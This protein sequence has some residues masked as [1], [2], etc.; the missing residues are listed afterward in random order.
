MR[1][2]WIAM[3]VSIGAYYVF[4]IIRGRPEALSP[5]PTV[6]FALLIGATMAAIVS[7]PIKSKLLAQAVDKQQ[8]PMVQ[9]AYVIA[10]AITE[11]GA[12]FGLLDFF[13]T[14]NRYF[15]APMIIA[16]CVQLLH[17]PRREAILNAAFRN[18]F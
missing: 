10:W 5:N 2:I 17:F 6:S 9:Q 3:L 11:V 4:T 8:V 1:T 13:M 14:G 12:I 16:A 18:T 7:F 15:F